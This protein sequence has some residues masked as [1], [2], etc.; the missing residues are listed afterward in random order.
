MAKQDAIQD[1]NRNAAL[2]AHTGT[3][4]TAET[5][6]VT[7]DSAG[8]L[9]VNIVSGEIVASLGTLE[10]GTVVSR[11]LHTILDGTTTTD[12]TYIGKAL[13]G[14][15]TDGT[16]WQIAKLDESTSDVLTVTW[17]DGNG[18]FDNVWS[19]RGTITYS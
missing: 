3:A 6:R 10:L 12:V 14:V 13:P 17:A 15:G 18:S 16:T 7:A 1:N 2:L 5:V 11:S 4:G 8:N 19:G 9:G